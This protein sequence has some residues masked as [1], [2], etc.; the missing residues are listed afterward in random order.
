MLTLQNGDCLELMSNIE[1]ESIDLILCDLPYQATACTW[2]ILIPFVELWKQYERIIKD[3]CAIVLFGTQPFTSHLIL[4]NLSLFKY[5]CIWHKSKCGSPLL[6][7]YKPMAKHENIVI[8]GKG[9]IK[10]VPQMK[11]G[12][13]YSRKLDHI[14][15]NNHKYGIK[16]IDVVNDGTRYPES[17]I[18]YPQKW[19]RQDQ[20]HPTQKPV[21]LLEYLIKTYSDEDAI[22][23]DNTMGSGS[24]GVACVNTKRNF[25][26]I[27]KDETYFHIAKERIERAEKEYKFKNWANVKK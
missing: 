22:V 24:T 21:E 26:G 10:Y 7:K 6:A 17:I 20:I 19:R 4:S 14:N 18:D 8:F 15:I 3:N 27:E 13:P 16:N 25:I 11:E 5:E 2:D 9:V 1:S 12:Q 23:L